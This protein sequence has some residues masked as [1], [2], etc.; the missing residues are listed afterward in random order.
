M[1]LP[2]PAAGCRAVRS[3]G[4]SPARIALPRG[5][6]TRIPAG[7]GRAGTRTAR[8]AG[9]RTPAPAPAHGPGPFGLAA[10]GS[11]GRIP[12]RIRLGSIPTRIARAALAP[13]RAMASLTAAAAAA[14]CAHRALDRARTG[15]TRMGGPGRAQAQAVPACLPRAPLARSA[16]RSRRTEAH[17]PRRR[18]RRRTRVGRRRRPRRGR[19]RA[20][21]RRP[22]CERGGGRGRFRRS[23]LAK[24]RWA[25]SLH[26]R[27]PEQV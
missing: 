22:R 9:R 23:G 15:S 27:P 14:P 2:G 24:K 10:R 4:G 5:P 19:V 20:T 11:P 3:P 12:S 21:R 7:P 26:P 13:R 25:G 17:T 6:M 8:V 16:A 1:Q 18:R